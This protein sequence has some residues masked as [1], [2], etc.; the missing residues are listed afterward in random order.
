MT[1]DNFK[2]WRGMDVDKMDEEEVEEVSALVMAQDTTLR[3]P[4]NGKPVGVESLDEQQRSNLMK[5]TMI[6]TH[7]KLLET[8][9]ALNA[10]LVNKH[11][12]I[13]PFTLAFKNLPEYSGRPE[14]LR[15]FSKYL[16]RLLEQYGP[17]IDSSILEILPN[18]LKGRARAAFG[19]ILIDY[20][21]VNKF[22][23]D[24]SLEFGTNT[25]TSYLLIQLKQMEQGINESVSD[26]GLRIQQIEQTLLSNVFI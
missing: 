8:Q 19:N 1:S 15:S 18:K 24:L 10:T 13:I 23:E 14:G 2:H 21:S 4:R 16:R 22:L 20:D 9:D 5:K 12:N 11:D 26:F 3:T 7:Q 6:R 17:G 25:D